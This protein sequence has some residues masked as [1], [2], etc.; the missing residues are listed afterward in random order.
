MNV[1]YIELARAL[2]PEG[3]LTF[4]AL[5]LL[6]IDLGFF[7][8]AQ[9]DVRLKVSLFI[10]SAAV[11]TAF[12]FSFCSYS[13]TTGID[14]VLSL[15]K[16]AV[17]TRCGA[18][19]LTF[20][21]LG[22]T[23]LARP[24]RHPVE[25]VAL[26]LFATAGITLMAAAQHLLVAFLAF[27]LTSLSLYT[28]VAFDTNRRESTEAA[29]KYFLFGGVSSAFLPFSFSLLY[30][31]TGAIDLRGIANAL[32]H[33]NGSPL[34]TL[35]LI[36]MLVAFGYKTA[37]APFHLW[38]PDAYQG[39]PTP[40]AALIAS[41]SKLGGLVMFSRLLWPSLVAGVSP[42]DSAHAGLAWLST[43]AVLSGASL[44]LGNLAALAQS[45]VRRLLA[46]SAIAH[47]GSLLLG[48]MITGPA[49]AGPLYYYALTYGIATAGAFGVI[50][51][52]E[53]NGSCQ[54]ITD[55][56]GLSRRSPLLAG[57]LLVFILSLAGIPPLAGFFGKLFV[58]SAAFKVGGLTATEGQL[59]LAAILLSVVS[60]YYYLVVL[61]QA[62]IAPAAENATGQIRVSP[63]G[64]LTL[65]LAASAI[66]LLGLF[67]S[68]L[69]GTV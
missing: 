1:N 41:G 33:Q 62:W 10:A 37:A 61:K 24:P 20:L 40:V 4:G 8:R 23:S 63:V 69:L 21:I 47:A 3:T 14:Q 54:Q 18:L 56:A 42:S 22:I 5:L 2:S 34:L 19:A 31:L 27:E 64:A 58:F 12:G 39:A 45:N 9:P 57:C 28:L 65:L 53:R 51:A 49:G 30:G 11:V 52:V 29:L 35:A 13:P 26:L 66:V 44:I 7:K 59:A 55:L 68:Y 48:V 25:Y 60:L 50:A 15:D 46:Y 67:P 38:A 16:L 6:A 32:A 36:M 43:V 17:A